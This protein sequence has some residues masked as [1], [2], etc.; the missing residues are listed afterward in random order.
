MVQ[1]FSGSTI[2]PPC[3]NRHYV[4]SE[5][6]TDNR[7]ALSTTSL[8]WG[9]RGGLA[10]QWL[11]LAMRGSFHEEMG[12]EGVEGGLGGD[13]DAGGLVD[14]AG[15]VVEEVVVIGGGGGVGIAAPEAET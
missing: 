6:G 11:V 14:P 4:L 5:C 8:R 7:H 10:V 12:A 1:P 13:V 15:P 3:I 2:R 9:V